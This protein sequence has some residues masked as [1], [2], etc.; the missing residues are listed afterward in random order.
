MQT[1][2]VRLII[3]WA[4]FL[5]ML[6]LEQ[7]VMFFQRYLHTAVLY[8]KRTIWLIRS[9]KPRK[10]GIIQKYLFSTADPIWLVSNLENYP[11]N[12]YIDLINE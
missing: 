5:P 8:H 1:G 7:M 9:T 3:G 6:R 10:I 2:L 11:L 4:Y 12:R